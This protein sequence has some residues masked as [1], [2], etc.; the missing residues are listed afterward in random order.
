MPELMSHKQ[1]INSSPEAPQRSWQKLSYTLIL[2]SVR[3]VH[4]ILLIN[5]A[6]CFL[7]NSDM[8][9]S[10]HISLNLFAYLVTFTNKRRFPLISY[11]VRTLTDTQV[12]HKQITLMDG[13]PICSLKIFSK[14]LWPPLLSPPVFSQIPFLLS[15]FIFSVDMIKP[16]YNSAVIYCQ[17]S[18]EGSFKC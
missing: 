9:C 5:I 11:H 6:F 15:V 13:V 1:Q 8:D 16:I 14:W 10:P 12:L 2:W 3:S 4:H 17:C 18:S 7:L